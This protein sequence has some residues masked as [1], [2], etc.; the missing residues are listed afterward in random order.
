MLPLEDRKWDLRTG[1]LAAILTLVLLGGPAPGG[2]VGAPFSF[3][4]TGTAWWDAA[5]THRQKL[6]ITTPDSSGAIN[7]AVAILETEGKCAPDGH[8]L[9]I[10][11]REGKPV[12]CEV[13]EVKNGTVKVEF[14]VE[15][16]PIEYYAYYGNPNAA[17]ESHSWEKRLGGLTLKTSRH[18]SG[19][20]PSNLAQMRRLIKSLGEAY[21]EGPREKIDDTR[22]P[23]GNGDEDNK[24]FVSVYTGKLYCPDSG[25]YVFATNSD[26]SSFL[27]IDGQLV[28]SWPESHDM[29]I[30]WTHKTTTQ[31][32]K[33]V[34][35]IEY[36]HVQT[37]GGTL[38]RAGWRPP[39]AKA[40][41]T[42]EPRY[43]IR[44]LT[45]ESVTRE[46]KDS[47]LDAFFSFDE[48]PGR[49]FNKSTQCFVPVLFRDRSIT[50]ADKVASWEW[51]F[52]DGAPVNKQQNPPHEYKSAGE[53]DVRLTCRNGQ[54]LTSATQRHVKLGDKYAPER[55]GLSLDFE[56]DSPVLEQN[57]GIALRVRF[58]A[59]AS[60]D[61]PARL[62]M[63]GTATSG[64]SIDSRAKDVLA[65]KDTARADGTMQENWTEEALI[66]PRDSPGNSGA[67]FTVR[68]EYLGVPMIERS[69][70]VAMARNCPGSLNLGENSLLD[71]NGDYLLLRV[72]NVRPLAVNFAERVGS[73][74][75]LNMVV[76][77]DLL[78]PVPPA[79][80]PQSLPALRVA[81]G[82][83]AT[84]SKPATA[85]KPGDATYY[86]I[87]AKRMQESFPGLKVSIQRLDGSI[88]E[89]YPALERV[90]KAPALAAKASPDL[91]VLAPSMSDILSYLPE[92][93]YEMYLWATIDRLTSATDA[94]I[95]L[96]TPPPLVLQP[97][98]SRRY[99]YATKRLATRLGIPVA[100]AFSAFTSLPVPWR[101]LYKDTRQG[102]E[103][104]CVWPTEKGQQLLADRLYDALMMR[105]EPASRRFDIS[106]GPL[107]EQR[108]DGAAP[109]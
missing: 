87:F 45:A 62:V 86:A 31:V 79:F 68:V 64:K 99:A 39:A 35:S 51:N 9:R 93:K 12:P 6:E 91:V 96:I 77:D 69:V 38:A 74:G 29:S 3:A 28:V 95:V 53:Y 10:V 54:G 66:P 24:R 63:K 2:Q 70:R 22:N 103:V 40:I 105:D 32:T 18:N 42:I 44:E 49:T 102:D 33:G 37:G 100:D 11:D 41:A 52:G 98:L 109:R 57:E 58:K 108:H 19:Q 1:A 56:S 14:Q 60:E 73:N 85:G 92:R 72:S 15:G 90:G 82:T 30:D 21:G 17:V 16:T 80:V 25:W 23:F 78:S 75:R 97:E 65:L 4:Q 20:A 71:E 13:A 55:V 89:E 36:Y 8:D 27:L 7:T 107:A 46:S 61:I 104:Y 101:E 106:G 84:A 47:G 83:L 43:F 48:Q 59:D 34:H 26:D 88:F 76:V 94:Q 67:R 5:W 81:G 50:R